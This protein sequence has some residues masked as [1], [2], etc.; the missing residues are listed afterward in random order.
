MIINFLYKFDEFMMQN[1]SQIYAGV[2]RKEDHVF[3]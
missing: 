2:D 1:K 3:A